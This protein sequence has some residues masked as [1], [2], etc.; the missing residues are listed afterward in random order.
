MPLNDKDNLARMFAAIEK[1]VVEHLDIKPNSIVLTILDSDGMVRTFCVSKEKTF[2]FVPL[3]EGAL[4]MR[5]RM[6]RAN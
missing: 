4:R 2:D 5:E 3:M 1:T 6:T